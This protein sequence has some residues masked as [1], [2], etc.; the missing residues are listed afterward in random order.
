[1]SRP[2]AATSVATR[3]WCLP[4]LQ[5]KSGQEGVDMDAWR[6]RAWTSREEQEVWIRWC[7]RTPQCGS[8]QMHD[9][10]Q[11]FRQGVDEGMSKA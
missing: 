6:Y 10:Y 9:D 8:H 1:M 11:P 7:G 5:S 3:T 4:A 2:R